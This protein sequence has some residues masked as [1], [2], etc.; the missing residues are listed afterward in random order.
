[1]TANE[2]LL[3]KIAQTFVGLDTDICKEEITKPEKKIIDL[4]VSDGWLTIGEHGEAKQGNK[5]LPTP[6][7]KEAFLLLD[8]M[9]QAEQLQE[10]AKSTGTTRTKLA[11][12]CG[13]TVQDVFNRFE[14]FHLDIRRR[15]NL[16]KGKL[17]LA[18]ALRIARDRKQLAN[19]PTAAPLQ[20]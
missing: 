13:L 11:D 12:I 14:L 8:P 3:R 9:T 17:T 18:T 10:I 2:I 19:D 20:Q 4:L 16:R 7:D 6:F 1:M 15:I 5:L